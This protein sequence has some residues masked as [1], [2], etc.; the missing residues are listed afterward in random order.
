MHVRKA[1]T[2]LSVRPPRGVGIDG[3]PHCAFYTF[4][5]RKFDEYDQ[6][7]TFCRLDSLILLTDSRNRW[8]KYLTIWTADETNINS[9][10]PLTNEAAVRI[11]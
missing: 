1:F 6:S 3:S 4:I 9:C 10:T 8:K 2:R 5:V 7:G 11:T